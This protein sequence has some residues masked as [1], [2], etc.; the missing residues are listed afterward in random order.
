MKL[1]LRCLNICVN[2]TASSIVSIL[3]S[4]HQ[5]STRLLTQNQVLTD[6]LDRTGTC[7]HRIDSI[8]P[9]TTNDTYMRSLFFDDR[10]CTSRNGGMEEMGGFQH[11]VLST[12]QLL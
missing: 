9:S 7:I 8:N 6:L 2:A 12:S 11:E 10:F 5:T 3:V 1:Q 4:E